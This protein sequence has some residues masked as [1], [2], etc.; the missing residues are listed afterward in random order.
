MVR[1]EIGMFVRKHEERLDQVNVEA[2]DSREIMLRI[3]RKRNI[4]R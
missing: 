4:L 3:K 2:I 1:N